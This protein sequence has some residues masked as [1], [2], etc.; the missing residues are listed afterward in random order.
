LRGEKREHEKM[1]KSKKGN[2]GKDKYN[3]KKK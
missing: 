1:G 2:K 3:V